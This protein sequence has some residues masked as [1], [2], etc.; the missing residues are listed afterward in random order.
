MHLQQ[1]DVPSQEKQGKGASISALELC[2]SARAFHFKSY[3]MIVP[4]SIGAR[5]SDVGGQ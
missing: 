5:V 4:G 2:S 3:C 1:G